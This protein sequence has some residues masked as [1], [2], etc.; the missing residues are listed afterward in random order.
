MKKPLKV[1]RFRYPTDGE[2]TKAQLLITNISFNGNL[3]IKTR[4]KRILGN[5]EESTYYPLSM[6]PD[7]VF[8]QLWIEHIEKNELLYNRRK[9]IF[10]IDEFNNFAIS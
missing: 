7:I 6:F 9:Y 10:Y 1:Y 8:N 2:L 3:A 5:I 4:V